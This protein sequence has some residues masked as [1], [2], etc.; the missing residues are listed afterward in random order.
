MFVILLCYGCDMVVLWLCYGWSCVLLLRRPPSHGA[1]VYVYVCVYMC[2]HIYVCV[3]VYIYM[4][5]YSRT[6]PFPALL[7]A[8]R[9]KQVSPL[10]PGAI[11][12]AP[13]SQ[14]QLQLV[15]KQLLL[16]NSDCPIACG[17]PWTG[18][19]RP[20]IVRHPDRYYVVV[21]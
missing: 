7:S 14:Q 1:C 21:C 13:A 3:C 6:H 17:L 12:F 16:N 10:G 18:W 2:V 4:Y 11:I 8:G 9:S 20:S 19:V 5:V 15:S